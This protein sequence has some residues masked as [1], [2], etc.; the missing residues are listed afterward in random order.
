MIKAGIVGISGYGG[1]ELFRILSGHPEVKIEIIKAHSSNGERLSTLYPHLTQFDYLCRDVSCEEMARQCDVIFTA[2]PHGG[3]SA[4]Y[5]PFVKQYQKKMIDLSADF[6]LKNKDTYKEWYGDGEEVDFRFLTEAVYGLPELHKEEIRKG[7]LIA[8]PGCYTTA[9]ILANAPLL[10]QKLIE[11]DS[12]IIDAKSGVSGAGRKPKQHLHY[13]EMEGGISAYAIATHRHTPEI[14]QELSLLAGKEV[15]LTFT[16]HLVPMIRGILAVSYA[17]LSVQITEE[18]L[19]ALYR[20]FYREEPFVRV[21]RE[22]LPCT[23]YTAGSN[24][25]DIAIRKE[26]RTGRVIVISSIDNLIKG[27]SGQAIQ[28]MNLMFG[29]PEKL[30]L[31]FV[32]LYP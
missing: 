21:V 27:A 5:V 24:Y 9:S 31:D 12:L 25:I 1:I 6:R 29:F 3:A 10:K 20:E 11:P 17:K 28:N 15:I 7:W 13:P 26:E 19:Y 14:E 4:A 32:S 22:Y 2:T 23:K 18:E 30:G 16:P 8:N